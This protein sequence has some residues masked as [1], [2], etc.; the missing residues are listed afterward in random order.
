MNNVQSMTDD[1]LNDQFA[2]WSYPSPEK[3]VLPYAK[4]INY[5]RA[6][7][8][9]ID[10]LADQN[11][12]QCR[13]VALSDTRLSINNQNGLHIGMV[14]KQGEQF[15]RMKFEKAVPLYD[16]LSGDQPLIT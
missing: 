9:S 5:F 16:A 10:Q 2:T 3:G 1:F 15:E 6:G 12:R 13:S 4:G 8:S 14:Y 7:M 11:V